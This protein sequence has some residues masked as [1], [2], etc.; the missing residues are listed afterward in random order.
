MPTSRPAAA[1]E[2]T[3]RLHRT[4][5][6]R[7]F[8][9]L[10][11]F[12]AIF[13]AAP[14][15]QASIIGD[16]IDIGE[17]IID[18]GDE[19]CDLTPWLPVCLIIENPIICIIPPCDEIEPP[20]TEPFY[21]YYAATNGEAKTKIKDVGYDKGSYAWMADYDE[22]GFVAYDTYGYEYTGSIFPI[23]SKPGK[24]QL[25]LDDES[26]DVF[27]QYLSERASAAAGTPVSVVL[28]ELPI[29]KLKELA[30]GYAKVKIKARAQT[31]TAE[32]LYPARY[33]CKMQGDKFEP[34][35]ILPTELETL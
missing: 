30:G 8:T 19:V 20:T 23:A 28:T 4:F 18:V 29:V 15:A 33:K 1:P 31:A 34:I 24:F 14:S 7:R 11:A 26:L 16:I 10:F 13:L 17:G 5:S 3:R 32:G 21:R 35:E 27:S 2:T 6:A 12:L 25:Q 9:Q 22:N